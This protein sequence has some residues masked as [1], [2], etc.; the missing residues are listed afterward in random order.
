MR[1]GP[2]DRRSSA[3]SG[4]ARFSRGAAIEDVRE[5]RDRDAASGSVASEAAGDGRTDGAETEQAQHDSGNSTVL[6]SP[7]S[8][9]ATDAP[10]AGIGT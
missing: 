10:G 1:V 5:L 6:M 7:S 4:D 8:P 3:G 9:P 2:D